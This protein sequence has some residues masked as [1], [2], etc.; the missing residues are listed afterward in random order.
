MADLVA[1][2]NCA[3]HAGYMTTVVGGTGN[4]QPLTPTEGT[5]HLLFSASAFTGPTK[6]TR[7]IAI[8]EIGSGKARPRSRTRL[9]LNDAPPPPAG[10]L[11]R[12]TNTAP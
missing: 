6:G 11:G 7:G 8:P 4:R 10:V 2:H 1:I 5:P 3:L 12:P 9:C